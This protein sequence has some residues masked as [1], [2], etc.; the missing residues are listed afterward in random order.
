M[1]A[2]KSWYQQK[3][4]MMGEKEKC[5][6][7]VCLVV[8]KASFFSR[9]TKRLSSENEGLCPVGP[10]GTDRRIATPEQHTHYYKN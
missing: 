6:T 4:S 10:T 7:S 9:F 3:H 5:S 8:Q 1:F 2:L